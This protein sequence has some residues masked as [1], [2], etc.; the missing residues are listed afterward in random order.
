[1]AL[2]EMK[3]ICKRFQ[4]VLAND[5][6]S[7]SVNSGE[8]HALLG[9]NGAGKTTLMNILYGMYDTW[10][11]EIYFGGKLVRIGSPREAITLGI[12][13][14]HQHF[15]LIP[16]LSVIENVI[17]GM[18]KPIKKLDLA[19][20]AKSFCEMAACYGMEIN[21]WLRVS[22]LTVGQQQRLEILKA[23]Y[24]HVKLLILDEP[25]AV[26]TPSEVTGLFQMIHKLTQNGLTV[27]FISHK[28]NEIM[29]LCDRCTILRQ[30]R[31]VETLPI[32]EV[33]GRE[34]LARLMVG[35]DVALENRHGKCQHSREV[36]RVES[37]S[38]RGPSGKDT[39]RDISF[40]IQDG[41]ILG[42]CGVDGNGQTELV[43]CITGLCPV[44]C[45]A[46]RI[47]G[48][49][50]TD[51]G[52][53]EHLALGMSHIPEDR[54]KFGIIQ[55]MNLEENL[56]LM[57]YKDMPFS[58]F[59]LLNTR[60]IRQKAMDICREFEVK[61]PDT[62]ELAVNLSGGNQQKLV[63][64]RELDRK[65]RLLIAVHPSRGLDIGATKYIQSRLLEE[66]NRGAAILLVST[67]LE[68]LMDLSDRILVLYEGQSMGI[69]DRES[70]TRD[71]LGL[72]M[73][74]VSM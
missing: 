67:E 73:G 2:L 29:E 48:C 9:E 18:E 45:G 5:D 44:K 40:D 36:L 35:K 30:G 19:A 39:L 20:A 3:H 32:S 55:T 27:I 11:G 10:E 25:T 50:C 59:G 7:F 47:E 68:E 63:V 65:P 61:A 1:M 46:I 52:V 71:S 13:M 26:L 41:E 17:L 22:Q 70:A 72:M 8:I 31:Y 58:R 51:L 4:N 38:C 16:A 57:C 66:R 42:I 43:S 62:K 33:Q 34:H 15:M 69:V 64:G 23:L 74:G 56:I 53:K 54:Q 37:L 60:Y 21:P 28:L 24:R 49:D 6:V 12:G 14:V